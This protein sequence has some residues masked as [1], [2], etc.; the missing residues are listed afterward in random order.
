MSVSDLAKKLKSRGWLRVVG[1]SLFV[2]ILTLID[3]T[4]LVTL[5]Q[6][7][8]L[9][10]FLIALLMSVPIIILR[11]HR[12]Y[13]IIRSEGEQIP[14]MKGLSVH[15]GSFALGI[16]TPGRLG[17]FSKAFFLF[18]SG[19]S[20][21]LSLFTVLFD[22]LSDLII[23]FIIGGIGVF[24]FFPERD[25][26][27]TLSVGIGIFF[28]V[29]I[30][31][32]RGGTG[33]E[34]II[35]LVD[36]IIPDRF[37]DLTKDPTRIILDRFSEIHQFRWIT[38]IAISSAAWIFYLIQLYFFNAALG[39]SLSLLSLAFIGSATQIVAFLPLSISGIGTRDLTFIVLVQKVG[40]SAE[41]GILMSMCI[42]FSVILYGAVSS[43]FIMIQPEMFKAK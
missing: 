33:K 43:V 4:Q 32:I 30:W 21:G 29:V 27:I 25:I 2:F 10:L 37:K 34:R 23:L 14:W 8:N 19:V 11:Y 40:E 28:M 7:I 9:M 18:K 12:W 16:I 20:F 26:R 5:I 13:Y 6:N 38:V 22:R 17:E 24:L 15:V 42:L 36:G 1:I 39:G 31:L 35:K 3:Y 41:Y